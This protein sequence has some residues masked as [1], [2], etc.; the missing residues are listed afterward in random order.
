MDAKYNN[1][2]QE[3]TLTRN[4]LSFIAKPTERQRKAKDGKES[5]PFYTFQITP[6]NLNTYKAWLGDDLFLDQL[7]GRLNGLMRLMMKDCISQD[8]SRVDDETFIKLVETYIGKGV[9]IKLLEKEREDIIKSFV[10]GAIKPE[11]MTEMRAKLK[12]IQEKIDA[13]RRDTSDED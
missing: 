6:E 1:W 12:D 4:G 8:G 2:P 5:H 11:Q 13:K 9:S 10:S 7:Q 3:L